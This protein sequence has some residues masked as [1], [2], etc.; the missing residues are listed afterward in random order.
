MSV[1]T[2]FS[3]NSTVRN[4]WTNDIGWS[5]IEFDLQP[6]INNLVWEKKDGY[7]STSNYYY[8]SLDDILIYYTE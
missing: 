3:I 1:G 5:Y 6:G 4:T 7:N 2:T 8:L